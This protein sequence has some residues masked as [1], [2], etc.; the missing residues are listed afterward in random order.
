MDLF[1]QIPQSFLLDLLTKCNTDEL[2]LPLDL[3]E[4]D[5]PIKQ[6]IPLVHRIGDGRNVSSTFLKLL[7]LLTIIGS[8]FNLLST[9][10]HYSL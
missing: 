7:F 9:H 8:I 10:S 1:P 3:T 4:I 2:S 5:E 6:Y